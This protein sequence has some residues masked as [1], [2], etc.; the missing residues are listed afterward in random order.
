M[1]LRAAP[2]T[3]RDAAGPRA[4]RLPTA[5]LLVLL[6][7]ARVA[8]QDTTLDVLDGE[9]LY[10]GGWL[11]TLG[12]LT[13]E[14]DDFLDG[15]HSTPDPLDREAVVRDTSL[16]VHHGLRHDL[17][18][19]VLLPRVHRR[20]RLRPQGGPSVHLDAQG[21]G[22]VVGLVKWR[23]H[24]WDAPHEAL[25]VSLLAGVEAPTGDDAAGDGALLLPA[26][27]QPGSGSWNPMLGVAATYEPGRWRFNAVALAT[28]GGGGGTYETP[29]ELFA[30]LSVGNRFWLEPYPG[31]FMRADLALRHER[32]ERVHV[33][34]GFTPGPPL[35][36][37]NVRQ[38]SGG[39]VT[40]LA[41]NWAFRPRPTLDFQLEVERP[42]SQRVHGTDLGAGTTVAFRFGYRF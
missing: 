23:F 11:V 36:N 19:S 39:E 9:T 33:A 25:N 22:D 14:R 34:D 4:G 28:K 3:P 29:D 26:D 32:T 8:A 20:L 12:T 5:L 42:L 10:D 21:P 16:A 1:T 30:E 37:S 40:S 27:L 7:A 13:V 24:R 17:Q 41:V 18:L 2:S 38:A 35:A 15:S 6:A 31:P